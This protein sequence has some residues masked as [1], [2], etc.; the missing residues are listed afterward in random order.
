MATDSPFPH[1]ARLDLDGPDLVD[2]AY[3][4]DHWF[5]GDPSDRTADA[6]LAALVVRHH[7]LEVVLL[8][9]GPAALLP[10]AVEPPIGTVALALG[11]GGWQAP[12][13]ADTARAH[14]PSRHPQRRRVFVTTVVGGPDASTVT[15]LRVAGNDAPTLV[16]TATSGRVPDALVRCWINL[17]RAS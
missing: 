3:C 8:G 16:R 6:V 7:G 17:R 2:V 13:D 12:S 14:R 11:V 4:F 9:S 5:D 1:S 15:V 10:D